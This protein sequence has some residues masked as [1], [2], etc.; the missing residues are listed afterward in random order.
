MMNAMLISSGMPTNMWGEAILSACYVLNRVPHKKLDKT[1]YELWKGFKP[2]LGYLKVWGCLGKIGLPDFQ[3]SK[4]GPK[5]VDD[6]P[7]GCKPIRVVDFTKK[8]KPDGSLDKYKARLVV[9]GHRQKQGLDF[10]DTYSP[11][12]KEKAVR[13]PPVEE[14]R[15]VVANSTHGELLR[16]NSDDEA[17]Q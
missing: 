1:P 5:T 3:R 6:L 17:A 16:R 7:R 12:T 9:G 13:L 2:N 11:V 8:C 14:I 10:F 4:I 15:T